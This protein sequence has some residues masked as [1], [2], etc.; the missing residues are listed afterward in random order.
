[1][2]VDTGVYPG[3]EITPYYDP[4]IAKLI[5]WGETRGQ[6]ILRMRRALEEYRIVGVRT[7]IPFH[8]MMM[9]SH[10][11]MGGQYDTRFVEE[12]FALPGTP[13]ERGQHHPDIAAVFA[14]LVAHEANQRSAEFVSAQRARYQQL[15][16]DGSL[17]TDAPLGARHEI[18]NHHRRDG[19]Q[20]SRCSTRA[21]SASTARSWTWT[22]RTSTDSRSIPW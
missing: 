22:S 3:F 21:T 19:I 13:G 2:R 4:M 8:Q 18:H 6:A 9:N 7:N 16:V 15:E 1:M 20:Q 5:V 12:R 17:G 14:T 10:R 11:F